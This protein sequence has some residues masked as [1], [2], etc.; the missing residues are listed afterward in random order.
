MAIPHLNGEALPLA[1]AQKKQ[2]G[3]L[4]G[5]AFYQDPSIKFIL[6]EEDRRAK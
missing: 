3:A 4:L 1:A 6:P 5:R 2:A